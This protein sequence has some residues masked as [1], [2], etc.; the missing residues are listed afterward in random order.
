MKKIQMVDLQSQYYKIK[1]DVDNAVLNVM[2]SAAFINGPEVKSFQAELEQYL[3]VKHVIPCANGTDALQIALMALD[4]KEGDE[5]ITADFTFAATVEVVHLL[6]LK[7]VL[8]DVDYDT[9]TIDID[10]LKAAITPKT[11]AIIPVHIFGQCA[12]MEEILKIAKEHNLFVIEDDAQAI[13]SDIIFTDGTMKKSGTMGILGTTSFFPSKNLGCYGD[14]GAIF[15]NDD[16]LAHKIRGIVNHG[17]YERYYHDEVGVNSRL[18]SI[19]ATVLRKKLPLLDGYNDARRKAADY[20]DEALAGNPNIL[21]PKRAEYSTHVFHQYTLRILNG[22]R[23]ELQ[24]F[25]TEKEVPAMIYYP[26]ALRKQKA[27]F[28]ESNDAD[29]VNTDKL[30]EQVISLPMH[31]ELD[32]EQLKYITDSV[33]EFMNK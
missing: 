27:Y 25:L 4:L 28:Q 9:F 15:T 29:F 10:K 12:N 13:G 19:Q 18:D 30:L 26:V 11:K 16:E 8:V 6:K 1:A 23:N 32:E 3:D 2:D 33:L 17:M 31:T 14:G 21:T 7:S 20:Y 22:K 5:V 24:K